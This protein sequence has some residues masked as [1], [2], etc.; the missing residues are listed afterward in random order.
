[1]R[2]A[3]VTVFQ[4]PFKKTTSQDQSAAGLITPGELNRKPPVKHQQ[5]P[6]G[7]EQT[8]KSV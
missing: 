5:T 6:A 1:M 4:C 3:A 7:A 2:G 8:C